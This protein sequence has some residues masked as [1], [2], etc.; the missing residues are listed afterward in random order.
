M[1]LQSRLCASF[2]ALVAVLALGLGGVGGPAVAE[3]FRVENRVFVDGDKEPLVKSTTIFHEGVVY[4]YLADPPEVTVFDAQRGR[5]VLLDLTRRV[6]TEL[7]SERVVQFAKRLKEWALEQS[8]P[9]LEFLGNP[10]F[11]EAFDEQTGELRLTSPWMSYRLA[12]VDTKSEAISEQYRQ[13]SD[14]H[15][16]LNTVLNPGAR[17]PFARMLV[18]AALGQRQRLPREVDLKIEYKEGLL[19]KR[20]TIRSEHLLV[21]QLVESDRRRVAQT[22]QFMAMYTSVD[23]DE[24]QRK[25]AN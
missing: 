14:W 7:T 1:M 12:T 19:P 11:D 20:V 2:G 21:R 15:C 22:D 13:F 5:F 23:F 8:D 17:P 16:R 24:Y 6:K 3:D 9:F 18:N 4:D 10:R 25:M